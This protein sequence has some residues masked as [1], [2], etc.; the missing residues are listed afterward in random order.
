MN[1]KAVS[2]RTLF[3]GTGQSIIKSTANLHNLE[4]HMTFGPVEATIGSARNKN[5]NY[6]QD[7]NFFDIRAH[8][9]PEKMEAKKQILT[10]KD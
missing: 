4:G 1:T 7:Y 2:P 9:S 3:G 5:I 10:D 8:T 6:P